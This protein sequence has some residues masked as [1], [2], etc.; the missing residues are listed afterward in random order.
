MSGPLISGGEPWTVNGLDADTDELVSPGT[1]IKPT[2]LAHL[3]RDR[4]GK[5]AALGVSTGRI[6][7]M[8]FARIA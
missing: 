6:K 3:E 4:G 2:Q 1:W 8:R 7:K 5:I